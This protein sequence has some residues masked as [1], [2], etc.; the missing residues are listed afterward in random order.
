MNWKSRL[1]RK[2]HRDK[3]ALLEEQLKDH[4]IT[5]A[6]WLE[7]TTS[8]LD[9]E[10]QHVQA[11]Y[12]AELADARIT[13]DQK[14]GL[15][16]REQQLID[17]IS[18]KELAAEIKATEATT[19]AWKSGADKVADVLNSQV[20]GLLKGTETFGRA[21]R[22]M[23]ISAVEDI[24][25]ALIKWGVEHA[26]IMAMNTTATI[27]AQTTQTAALASGAAAQKAINATTVSRRAGRSWRLRR[28]GGHPD[29]WPPDRSGG[30][31]GGVRRGR[32]VRQFR[33]GPL[34]VTQRHVRPTSPRRNG[35]ASRAYPIDPI[36]GGQRSGQR[37]GRRRGR[38]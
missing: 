12:A 33:Y 9:A 30:C 21:F 13:S 35:R 5:T 27:G 3:E 8:A 34:G 22:N 29:H 14:A 18:K 36:A 24:I 6:Q 25:T 31:G 2:T 26:A 17:E 7:Q 1:S 20:D 38:P 28:I 32:G 19:A 37:R 11:T 16:V 15:R 23:M 4:K 10:K